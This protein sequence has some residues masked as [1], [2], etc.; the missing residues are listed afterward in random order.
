MTAGISLNSKASTNTSGVQRR[1]RSVMSPTARSKPGDTP[2]TAWD[3]SAMKR[4]WR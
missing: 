2:E 4:H 3:V 1:S